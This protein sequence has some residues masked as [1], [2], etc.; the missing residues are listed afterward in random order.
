[1][2]AWRSTAEFVQK[3]FHK[4]SQIIVE[5]RIQTR[6]WKDN[7]GNN[8]YATEIVASQVNFCGSK[9]DNP[10]DISADDTAPQTTAPAASVSTG[11]NDD[12][13]E[14]AGDDDL[15]F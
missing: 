13:V 4:G 5:G 9:K 12:F 15:P 7:D 6:K 11:S 1:V 3:Y 2:V 10:I 14:I 8:R